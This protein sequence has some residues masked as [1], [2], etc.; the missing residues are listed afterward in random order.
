MRAAL[1]CVDEALDCSDALALLSALQAP[2]LALRGLRRENT[3]WYLEQLAADREQKALVSRARIDS[4]ST[5]GWGI[6]SNFIATPGTAR[7]YLFDI[8]KPVVQ[9]LMFNSNLIAWAT[10]QYC[11]LP[12]ICGFTQLNEKHFQSFF[13]FPY[14]A[15]SRVISGS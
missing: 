7:Q 8:H 6:K 11:P 14:L 2:C 12:S 4:N 10:L 3:A 1:E 15:S 9:N 13:F 5:F